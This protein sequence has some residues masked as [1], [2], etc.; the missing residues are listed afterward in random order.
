MPKLEQFI[1]FS[2]SLL[3]VDYLLNLDIHNFNEK[4]LKIGLTN[5]IDL[6][7]TKKLCFL[8]KNYDNEHFEYAQELVKHTLS[9]TNML[10]EDAKQNLFEYLALSQK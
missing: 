5:L 2:N 7:K 10:N 9:L 3:V 8:V 4:H 6:P 1:N